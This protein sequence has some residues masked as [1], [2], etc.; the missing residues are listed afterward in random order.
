M[1]KLSVI[2]LLFLSAAAFAED[3]SSDNKSGTSV[4]YDQ[5]EIIEK[6]EPKET[7]RIIT[8]EE[9]D[10]KGTSNLWEIM[11]T[12]PGVV[13]TGGGERNESN[14]RLRGFDASRVPVYIDGVSQAIPYRGEADHGRILTYDLESIEIQK[15]YSS[16]LMGSNTLGGIVNL[17]TAKPKKTFESS[18]RFNT[19]YD[20]SFKNQ[21]NMYLF[22]V[23]TRQ[24]S[25]Y[26]KITGIQ[27][28]QSHFRL[29]YSFTPVSD[30]QSSHQ[31]EDSEED[32]TKITLV[33]G[34]SP[35]RE[36]DAFVTYVYQRANKMS[37]GDVTVIRPRIWDWTRWDRDSIALNASYTANDYYIKIL[38]Y[39]DK[40]DNRLYNTRPHEIPT[41]YDDFALGAKIQGGIDFNQRNNLQ[42]SAMWKVESHTGHGDVTGVYSKDLI[43]DEHTYSFGME[44]STRPWDKVT[45]AF[46]LGY[47]KLKPV[48]YWTASRGSESFETTDELDEFVYQAG[49]FYDLSTSHELY[50]TFSKK[51]HFPTMFERFSNRYDTVIPNPSLKP[52]YAH[53]Y[54]VGYK[55]FFEKGTVQT[56][57]YYSDFNNKI[58]QELE[59]DPITGQVVTHSVN[60][61]KWA[62]YGFELAGEISFNKFV[63]AGGAFSYNKSDN[64]H[65]KTVRDAY[66]PEYT[67]NG[68]MVI[69]P[70]DKLRIVP[71]LEYTGSRYTSSDTTDDSRLGSYY[72]LHLTAKLDQVWKNFFIEGGISNILDKEYALRQYYP[73]AGR[74]FSFTVGGSF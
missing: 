41:D 32:D 8:Q 31:R 51:T 2:I 6:V 44:Y 29:P 30:Y 70:T 46:G 58:L 9:M 19:E 59:R 60:K 15:G 26:A 39:Y 34:Y 43:I 61:D 10:I 28:D 63:M 12:I 62:Y 68:Y 40:F 37:P 33:A 13:L 36:F 47:D 48:D 64:N 38:T 54:E 67:S 5:I 49:L 69:T 57:V 42:M 55:G 3:N 35:V 23:G 20:S 74:V 18:L 14:F 66:Y 22:S 1:K 52:E 11:G 17:I 72:L 50:M 53:H 56:S 4:Y 65:D 27:I 71:R 7:T 21:K 24:D 25:F 73:Q 45:L 16:M